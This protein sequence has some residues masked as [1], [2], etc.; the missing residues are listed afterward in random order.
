VVVARV[1]G[2]VV[3]ASDEPY[4]A[5]LRR[6]EQERSAAANRVLKDRDYVGLQRTMERLDRE[7]LEAGKPR[8]REGVPAERAV[9]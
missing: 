2:D 5:A 3:P 7:E 1:V 9:V 8:Q 6:I 4:A